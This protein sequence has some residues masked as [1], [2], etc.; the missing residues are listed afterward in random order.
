MTRSIAAALVLAALSPAFAAEREVSR[1]VQ[2]ALE[3]QQYYVYCIGD[4][5]SVEQWDLEQMKVRRGSDVC[6]LYQNTSVS[7]AQAWMDK[8][9]PTHECFCDN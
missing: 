7:S 1:P 6:L 9:F 4:E 2:L 5:T 3:A 8:N